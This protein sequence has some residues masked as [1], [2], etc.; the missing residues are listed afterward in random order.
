MNKVEYNDIVFLEKLNDIKTTIRNSGFRID[1]DRAY[2]VDK[3]IRKVIDA[4]YDK[5]S[6]IADLYHKLDLNINKNTM[7]TLTCYYFALYQDNL[8]L[9]HDM[10]QKDIGLLDDNERFRFELLDH[11]FTKYF[12]RDQYLFLVQYCRDELIRF[13]HKVFSKV[14]INH[15]MEKRKKLLSELNLLSIKLFSTENPISERD[16]ERYESRLL[17]ISDELKHFYA[18]HYTEKQRDEY[19]RKFADIMM[20]QPFVAKKDEDTGVGKDCYDI[21]IPELFD[22]FSVEDYCSMNATQKELLSS[23]SNSDLIIKRLKEL[24]KKYPDY[25]GKLKLSSDLLKLF[26]DEDLYHFPLEDIPLYERAS[27]EHI[28]AR[29]KITSEK[30]P[31]IKK[32][33]DFIQES[34]YDAL[35]DSEITGLSECAIQRIGNLA[36]NT[37]MFCEEETYR[38]KKRSI[39]IMKLD[40]FVQKVKKILL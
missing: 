19:C 39:Q 33:P 30:N 13:Y 26:T 31:I 27:S 22:E 3:E 23:Y 2:E 6:S 18:Y 10:L 29:Y 20:L 37:K 5:D 34:I 4:L 7:Y 24:F 11:E 12:S 38:L 15:D 28:S 35:T 17:E 32:Y 36:V 21:L 16:R 9:L 25:A 8:S 1:C 40:R 14:S